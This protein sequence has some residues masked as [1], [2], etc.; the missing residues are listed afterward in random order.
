MDCVA[1]LASDV[2]FG[3]WVW[4]GGEFSPHSPGRRTRDIDRQRSSR[5]PRR[6]A[7]FVIEEQ[8]LWQ[9]ILDRALER[10]FEF[11]A[12]DAEVAICKFEEDV[13]RPGAVK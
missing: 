12:P 10:Q 7:K 13:R 11:S 2:G 3:T 6:L 4:S 9:A 8:R 5:T 1:Y